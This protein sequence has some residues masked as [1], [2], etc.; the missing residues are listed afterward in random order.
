MLKEPNSLYMVKMVNF[1]L[2]EFYLN[3]R[4]FRQ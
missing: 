2:Q 4:N 3:K 1:I